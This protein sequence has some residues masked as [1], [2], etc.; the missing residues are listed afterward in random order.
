MNELPAVDV[1]HLVDEGIVEISQRHA[2]NKASGIVHQHV[3][4]AEPRNGGFDQALRRARFRQVELQGGDTGLFN[5]REFRPATQILRENLGACFGES[6]RGRAA[7]SG[8]AARHHH[9]LALEIIE[10]ELYPSALRRFA[11]PRR[12]EVTA[13]MRSPVTAAP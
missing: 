10:H 3:D 12:T 5:G 11:S 9:N 2:C 6:E 1:E 8:D 13:G 4:A 7:N